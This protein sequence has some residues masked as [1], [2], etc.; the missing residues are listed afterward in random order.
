VVA[1]PLIELVDIARYY[2]KGDDSNAALDG[3][4]FTVE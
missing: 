3:L 1:A 4:S 2:Q